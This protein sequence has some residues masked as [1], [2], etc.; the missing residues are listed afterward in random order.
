MKSKKQS[1]DRVAKLFD[2]LRAGDMLRWNSH[3]KELFET[4][5]GK[6]LYV[7]T[8][9]GLETVNFPADLNITAIDISSA[10]LHQSQTK[11]KNYPGKINLCQMDAETSAFRDNSFDTVVTVCVLCTV[12]HPVACLEEIKRVLKPEGKLVMFEHVLS[13]NPL[14]A[15]ALKTMSNLTEFLEGTYLDR[16]TVTNA[17]KAGFEILSHK[18]VYLD[19]VKALVAKAV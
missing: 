9:T 10:M 7:G 11:A 13:K 14:Y 6:V 4:L 2:F 19:I 18:N 15:I 3:Q 5:S 16:D 8:G 1:Y 17:E 12:K